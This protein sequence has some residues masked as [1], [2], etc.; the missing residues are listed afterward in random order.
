MIK[1]RQQHDIQRTIE[2]QQEAIWAA[3]NVKRSE[4]NR[5]EK[6]KHDTRTAKTLL[7]AVF[8]NRVFHHPEHGKAFKALAE[9]R[10]STFP[11]EQSK[12]EFVAHL[13]NGAQALRWTILEMNKLKRK[14]PDEV[15]HMWHYVKPIITYFSSCAYSIRK[16]HDMQST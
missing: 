1:I 10:E 8:G 9:F 13:D 4:V 14:K 7:K 6:L 16:G 15:Q 5:D 2:S 12:G 11:S 3:S